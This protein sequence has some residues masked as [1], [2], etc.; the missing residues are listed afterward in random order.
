[1]TTKIIFLTALTYTLL[2]FSGDKKTIEFNYPRSKDAKFIMTS[3]KF[4]KF[5]IEWRSE[6]YYYM[7]ENGDNDITCTVLFRKLNKAKQKLIVAS[8]K[9]IASSSLPLLYFADNSEL[10]KYEINNFNWGLKTDDFMF[11]QN[12][13]QEFKGIKIKQKNMYAYCIFD[14]EVFVKIHLSKINCTANDSIEMRQILKTLKK[15]K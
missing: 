3:D 2:S 12:D 14:E 9:E 15:K 4:E 7:S 11:R 1:M 6:D 8:S 13:I 5:N 10:K